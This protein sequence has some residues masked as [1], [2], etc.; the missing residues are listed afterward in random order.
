[1]EKKESFVEMS[2]GESVLSEERP[3]RRKCRGLRAY[4]ILLV[5]LVILVGGYGLLR[6]KLKSQL[7]RR[8]DAIR[9]AGYPV[10]CAE[11]DKW[12]SIPNDV[13]NAAD[14]ILD[15][16]HYYAAP[17]KPELMPVAGQ[18][19]LPGRTEPLSKETRQ[20]IG[21]YLAQNKRALELLGKAAS[22]EHSRYPI[23]LSAGFAARMPHLGE[24][25]GVA[26]LLLLD[27]IWHAENNEGDEAVE[28]VVSIFGVART[29]AKKP[30]IVSQLI[31]F[32]CESIGVSATERVVNRMGLGDEQLARLSETFAQGEDESGLLRGFV[33]ERCAAFEVL[34]APEGV[35]AQVLGTPRSMRLLYGAYRAMG[36]TDKG[37]TIYLDP[38]DRLFDALRLAEHE[39]IKAAE[40]IEAELEDVPKIYV[41]LRMLMPPQSRIFQMS[42]NNTARLRSVRAG[43]AIERYRLANGK[44]P[45]KLAELVPAYLD[46]VPKDPFDGQELRYKRLEKG[47]VVYSIGADGS[48]DGGEER[49]PPGKRKGGKKNWD[50]TFI[51]ER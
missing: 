10:T 21:Q 40:A 8:M 9:A 13:E 48:D 2:N 41:M 26:R 16:T 32:D 20:L 49:L 24:I 27:A 15:A 51:V 17:D 44:L 18:A 36:L 6:W 37:A 5:A 22:I 46:A 47:Y 50:V 25:R 23:D 7:Q 38:M 43:L 12:Y 39:R 29:L 1:L 30:L 34:R 42:L 28:A 3:S 4:H 35:G 11:L 14:V 33:G 31:R 19:E 45:E